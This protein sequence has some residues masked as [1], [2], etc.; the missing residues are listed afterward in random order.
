MTAP[1]PRI[2]VT[3]ASSGL[4]AA[5]A[6]RYAAPGVEL[7]LIARGEARLAEV[8]RQCVG[9]GAGATPLPADVA[10]ASAV[11]AAVRHF[12]RDGPVDLLVAAA[13]VSAGVPEGA[14]TE[15]AASVAMQVRTNL[16]GVVHVVE[17][18]A[19]DMAARGEGVIVVVSSVAGLRGLPYS[20]GYSASKA[21]VRAYGE[22]MRALL[23]PRGVHVLVTTP[24]FF[25]TPMTDRWRGPTPGLWS[26]DRTAAA[27]ARAAAKRQ[28]RHGF[29]ASLLLGMRLADLGPPWLTDRV[30]RGFRFRID[31]P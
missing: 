20:P 24:G 13:G 6:V 12:L 3:G 18:V 28:A 29:P 15:G 23:A 5:L 7:G 16:L 14:A 8:A 25:D 11:E 27:T 2:L 19:Q 17:P 1:P 21:G 22:A 9:R 31:P 4:G 26:L 10:D 30:L